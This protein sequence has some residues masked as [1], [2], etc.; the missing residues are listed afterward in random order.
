[1]RFRL[2]DDFRDWQLSA[3]HHRNE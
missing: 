1:V 3:Q 2:L